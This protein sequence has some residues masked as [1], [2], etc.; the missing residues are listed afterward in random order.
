VHLL[1]GRN[2]EI[3]NLYLDVVLN[4]TFLKTESLLLRLLLLCFQ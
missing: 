4:K 2:S 1:C 3:V